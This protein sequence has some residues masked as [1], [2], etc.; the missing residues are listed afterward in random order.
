MRTRTRPA[1]EITSGTS[2][3]VGNVRN[4]D[5]SLIEP[6]AHPPLNSSEYVTGWPLAVT[7]LLYVAPARTAH[8]RDS[9]PRERLRA[10]SC[11]AAGKPGRMDGKSGAGASLLQRGLQAPRRFPTPGLG[12]PPQ[13]TARAFVKIFFQRVRGR[14]SQACTFV[15]GGAIVG[16]RVSLPP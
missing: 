10:S 14:A 8:L 13:R 9:H 6:I 1:K 4:N 2:A 5:P 12:I 15:I 16:N 11:I 3:R 7:T